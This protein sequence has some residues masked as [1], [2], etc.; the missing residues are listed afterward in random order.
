MDLD[1][2]WYFGIGRFDRWI[3]LFVRRIR[4][5]CCCCCWSQTSCE[6]NS[7]CR[8]LRYKCH[9]HNYRNWTHNYRCYWTSHWINHHCYS[10]CWYNHN[11]NHLCDSNLN[12]CPNHNN[13]HSSLCPNYNW[14]FRHLTIIL[15]PSFNWNHWFKCLY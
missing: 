15:Y 4:R 3:S 1:F 7:H 10:N 2:G 13:H 11:W 8:Y 9:H 14:R 12:Y 5:S 6:W